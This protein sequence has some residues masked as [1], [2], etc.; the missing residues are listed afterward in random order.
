MKYEGR[1]GRV[2]VSCNAPADRA[3]PPRNVQ[4]ALAPKTR[5][6]ANFGEPEGFKDS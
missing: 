2:R 5:A 3:H 6:V 1:R 4:A